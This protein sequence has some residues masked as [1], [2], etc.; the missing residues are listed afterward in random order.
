AASTGRP[1][2]A[3]PTP[4]TRPPPRASRW[5]HLFEGA[6][7]D[8]VVAKPPGIPY[9]QDRRVMFKVKHER[10]ADCVVAGFRWHKSGPVV[11]SLLLGLYEEEPGPPH[12]RVS[13]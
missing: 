2:G 10:T 3:P 12:A 6:G 5:F 11:G 9:E 4:T 8:G 13:E 7:L 1:R